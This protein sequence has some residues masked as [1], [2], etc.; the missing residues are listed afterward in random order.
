M[1]STWLVGNHVRS[2]SA[3]A[4]FVVAWLAIRL[5]VPDG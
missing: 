4:A 1:L 2:L 3:I 5:P